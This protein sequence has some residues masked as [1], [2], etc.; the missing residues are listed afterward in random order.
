MVSETKKMAFL[1]EEMVDQVVGIRM[2]IKSITRKTVLFAAFMYIN[3]LSDVVFPA[4][5]Q[6]F[7]SNLL[8]HQYVSVTKLLLSL[9][10]VQKCPFACWPYTKA[11]PHY[12]FSELMF[13]C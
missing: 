11:W 2:A 12:N 7:Y 8:L 3:A 1:K 4:W 6:L 10:T 13:N 9:A 5:M